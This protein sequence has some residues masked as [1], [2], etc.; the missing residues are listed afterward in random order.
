MIS[1]PQHTLGLFDDGY[2]GFQLYYRHVKNFRPAARAALSHRDL[3]ALIEVCSTENPVV[4]DS[5]QLAASSGLLDFCNQYT[6][7]TDMLRA[8]VE[9]VEPQPMLV[10]TAVAEFLTS[11]AYSEVQPT[12]LLVSPS[13]STVWLEALIRHAITKGVLCK[14]QEAI[15][16]PVTPVVLTAK[17]SFK[18][19]GYFPQQNGGVLRYVPTSHEQKFRLTA[20]CLRVEINRI[21]NEENGRV[22]CV[23]IETP[24]ALGVVYDDCDINEFRAL[25]SSFP[26]ILFIQDCYNRGT[27]HS[28]N[29]SELIADRLPEESNFASVFSFRRSWGAVARLAHVSAVYTR[30]R[31]LLNEI[32]LDCTVAQF[33]GKPR[34][35]QLQA[36]LISR[37]ARSTADR[38]MGG[39]ASAF[40]DCASDFRSAIKTMAISV[41]NDYSHEGWLPDE[42]AW[43][44]DVSSG[45]F[46]FYFLG[47]R[48]ASAA[49]VQSSM[50]LAELMCLAPNCRLMATALDPMG[51]SG[52][53]VGV[54][55]NLFTKPKPEENRAAIPAIVARLE[56]FVRD[57]IGGTLSYDQY[58]ASIEQYNS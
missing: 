25:V 1:D 43:T 52:S 45:Q 37:V 49:G 58:K 50:Q 11:T 17:G 41:A 5:L 40:G 48:L 27:E 28:G 30:N 10:R 2:A 9:Y 44:V 33:H 26:T 54:R 29:I 19:G 47:D 42:I 34:F 6:E 13:S 18:C 15:S 12:Q 35:N 20:E 24:S 46:V 31:E 51:I 32:G 23:I 53:P 4:S 38:T 7:P 57:V 16:A 56:G 8:S 14:N 55:L 21:E 3:I 22:A 36:V 39:F